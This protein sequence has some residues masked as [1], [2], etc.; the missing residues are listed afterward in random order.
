MNHLQT[1]HDKVFSRSTLRQQCVEWKNQGY[2]LVFSNGCFDIIHPGH[3]TYLAKAASL[4]DKLIMGLNTDASVRRLK[5]EKRPVLSQQDRSLMLA[6]FSFVD[7]V[8]LF[9]EDTPFE[10][11]SELLPHVLVKGKDYTVDQ[12]VG[13]DVV[14]AAGGTVETIELVEGFSTTALIQKIKDI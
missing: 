12:I 6:A 8:C 4:G 10:L 9:D 5:G 7:A 11:I 1:I 13:A 3:V 14:M 2:R